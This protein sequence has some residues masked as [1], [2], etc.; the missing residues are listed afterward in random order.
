MA[1]KE[2]CPRPF[3]VTDVVSYAFL[4]PESLD[5]GIDISGQCDYDASDGWKYPS[6]TCEFVTTDN[7]EVTL[8]F[9]GDSHAGTFNKGL[10]EVAVQRSWNV[11]TY[12]RPGCNGV[13]AAA[14]QS[15]EQQ[16]VCETWGKEVRQLLLDDP[17]LDLV[18][19]AN[20][21]GYYSSS[22]DAAAAYFAELESAGR[23]VAILRDFAGMPST[24]EGLECVERSID[25]YDP[26]TSPVSDR[27]D[28]MQ[29]AAHLAD[30]PV[31]DL[32]RFLCDPTLCHAVIGELI[33]FH[34]DNHLSGAFARTLAPYLADEIV[35]LPDR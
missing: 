20:Y 11:V 8:A 15:A 7:P 14:G 10:A 25:T 21:S 29:Q 5:S 26:C 24:V 4:D 30:V 22:E 28:F 3:S 19:F 27:T 31:I 9:V 2:E 16:A 35:A 34:D 12:T 33:V 18:L 17:A 32:A 23:H 13:T 1:N 6:R